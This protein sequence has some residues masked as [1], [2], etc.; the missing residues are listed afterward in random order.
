M[1]ALKSKMHF[2]FPAQ[3]DVDQS[4]FKMLSNNMSRN[5]STLG[6]EDLDSFPVFIYFNP[7]LS[8]GPRESAIWCPSC[9]LAQHTASSSGS[10]RTTVKQRG[11]GFKS[12]TSMKLGASTY[13][14][15]MMLFL[16]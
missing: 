11:I 14:I 2:T 16:W 5:A 1:K 6:S 4:C 3:L 8:G 7:M 15:I 12:G 9:C 10:F 13:D